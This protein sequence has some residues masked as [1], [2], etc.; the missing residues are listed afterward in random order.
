MYGSGY[1]LRFRETGKSVGSKE[2]KTSEQQSQDAINLNIYSQDVRFAQD[3]STTG[4]LSNSNTGVRHMHLA[5]RAHKH[6]HS[7]L[8][9][10][11]AILA[12]L[13]MNLHLPGI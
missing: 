9:L 4:I 11:S 3:A 5:T 2:C 1:N 8:A 13:R 7:P 6:M 10:F 12:L